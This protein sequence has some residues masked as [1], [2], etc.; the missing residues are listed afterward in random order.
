MNLY[1]NDEKSALD[2][3]EINHSSNEHHNDEII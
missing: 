3:N 1:T 2:K